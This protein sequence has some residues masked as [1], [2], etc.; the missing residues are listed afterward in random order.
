MSQAD[1]ITF[2]NAYVGNPSF[3]PLPRLRETEHVLQATCNLRSTWN[4]G[5]LGYKFLN[6]VQTLAIDGQPVTAQFIF[7]HN[8]NQQDS[9]AK[10]Q[11]PDLAIGKHTLRCEVISALVADSDMAGLPV[12]APA[13]DWPPAKR[14]WSR[15]CQAE[16]TIY[17]NDANIVSLTQDPAMDP[18]ASGA[19]KAPQVIIRPK[20]GHLTA[21]TTFRA[22]PKTN[23]AISDDVTLRLADQSVSCGNM[24]AEKDSSGETSES[25]MELTADI[26]DLGPNIKEAEV[27]LTP[28]TKLIE[29]HPGIYQIWGREI[30]FS[31][32]PVVRQD[33]IEA[34]PAVPSSNNNS[35]SL[36]PIPSQAAQL[37]SA[38]KA[39]GEAFSKTHDLKDTKVMTQFG[40]EMS[41]RQKEIKNLLQGTAV[42]PLVRQ[43]DELIA[44]LRQASQAR[45]EEKLR[46][47]GNEAKSLGGQIEKMINHLPTFQF[48]WAAAED[49]DSS[50]VD[51]LPA[52][53]DSTGQRAF[54]LLKTAMLEE[55]EVDSA[56]FT[57]YQPG[58]KT[59]AV[60]V[61]P[62]SAER[63][64]QD[65]QNHL[66]RQ[67]ALVL[68]DRVLRMFDSWSVTG[69]KVNLTGTL[70]DAESSRLLDL[71]NHR[72][73][74]GMPATNPRRSHL[75]MLPTL[76]TT[77]PPHHQAIVP[78]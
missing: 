8:W 28:N 47:L 52:A 4:N 56:G 50:P 22:D 6:E 64:S 18:V 10:F 58:Q 59:L 54:R 77:T 24:W 43:Q 14:R 76:Q 73:T 29:S 3:K 1:A 51:V 32:V 13:R 27:I 53:G 55:Y 75:G 17:S 63:I 69:G 67:I 16:F 12:D 19:L 46:G 38:M 26:H 65:A 61:Y 45:D 7:G 30:V 9:V 36:R 49:D 2:L 35:S 62:R 33:L 15:S 31:H 34:R 74:P 25:G 42:E 78:Y 70:N 68:Q 60:N 11:L 44:D 57:T 5:L 23:T 40:K 72:T 66:G 71:L 21:V 37:L 20:N 48:R 39:Y 41:A